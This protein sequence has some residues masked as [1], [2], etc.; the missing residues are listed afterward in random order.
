MWF[1][2]EKKYDS[3]RRLNIDDICHTCIIQFS[4]YSSF[5]PYG[6]TSCS[7]SQRRS[8]DLL[9]SN[10]KPSS[11]VKGVWSAPLL[12]KDLSF[13]PIQETELFRS[14]DTRFLLWLNNANVPWLVEPNWFRP[15]VSQQ[16][17]Q[18]LNRTICQGD[19][20]QK[21]WTRENTLK[22]GSCFD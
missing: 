7:I 18:L 3:N 15:I 19:A 6:R 12:S 2:D 9:I 22:P 16:K 21:P 17:W 4:V 20:D 1:L 8:N 14:R 13:R 5:V 10:Y 11:L